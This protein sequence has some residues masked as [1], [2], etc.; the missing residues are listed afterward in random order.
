MQKILLLLLTFIGGTLIAGEGN[1]KSFEVINRSQNEM[2]VK[3]QVNNYNLKAVKKDNDLLGYL[4]DIEGGAKSLDQGTPDLQ[5]LTTSLIIG[6]K[7]P[8]VKVINKKV[9]TF[10]NTEILPSKGKIYRN[11]DPDKIPYQKGQVYNKDEFYPGNIVKFGKDYQFRAFKGLPLQIT[12]MQYNPVSKEFQLFTELILKITFPKGTVKSQKS[13]SREFSPMYDD[14]FLNYQSTRYNPINEKGEMLVF[15]HQDF[16][17]NIE[18]FVEWKNRIGIPTQL[19]RI[20]TVGNGSAQDIKNYISNYYQNNNLTFVLLVGDA[21]YVP[22]HNLS[23]GHSDHA[24]GYLQGNDSYPEVMVGRFSA[25][26]SQHVNTMVNRTIMYETGLQNS[27]DWLNTSLGISSD[28]GPGDNNE[29]DYEHIRNMHTDLQGYTYI[30]LLEMFDGSQGGND[31]SGDPTPSMVSQAINKGTGNILYTGHGSATSWSSS[32]FSNSEI[33]QLTNTEIWPFIWSVACVNGDFVDKTCFAES[34]TR[35]TNNGKPTGAIATQMSSINQSWDPPMHAQDE[36]VDILIESYSNNIKRTFSGISINGCMKMNDAYG[37]DGEEMTD[38]WMIFGDP[39]FMV[40]TDTSQTISVNSIPALFIGDTSLTVNTSV[41]DARVALSINNELLDVQYVKNGSATLT[42]PA[43]ANPDTMDLA[44]VAYNHDIYFDE[45]P[46]M[47][48]NEPYVSFKNSTVDDSQA[49]NDQGAD[50]GENIM[51]DVMLENIGL[52]KAQSVSANLMTSDTNVVITDD[53]A[54]WGDIPSKDSAT[55]NGA[56]GLK[57]K[58]GVQNGYKVNLKLKI[59][60]N[61]GNQWTDKF[62]LPVEAPETNVSSFEIVDDT[63][64]NGD[65]RLNAGEEASIVLDVDNIGSDKLD[66]AWCTLLSSSTYLDVKKPFETIQNLGKSQKRKLIFKVEVDTAMP[67]GTTVRFDLDIS[68]GNY[69]SITS[70]YETIGNIHEGFETRNFTKFSWNHGSN[71]GWE[72]DTTEAYAGDASAVSGLP[73]DEH[74]GISILSIS[75][76]TLKDDT[77][78]FYRKVNSE[79]DYDYLRF[80]IDNQLEDEWAGFLD[81]KRYSYFVP[82]GDHVFKWTYEKD[83][84][85]SSGQDKAWIDDIRFPAI[86]TPTS[87]DKNIRASSIHVYPNPANSKQN[88]ELS[89]SKSADVVINLLDRTGKKIRNIHYGSMTSGHHKISYDLSELSQGLYFLNIKVGGEQ[90]TIK[91]MH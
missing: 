80:F 61:K 44:V 36:M 78:S 68:A 72:I 52:D 33:N 87:V 91:I 7:T 85:V 42:F 6:N 58:K 20:D 63:T 60:D 86:S 57:V 16:V 9:K 4:P 66:Y 67:D 15:T 10:S 11:Q 69:S 84:Y 29:M 39:S 64:G 51:L 27:S 73:Y 41:N 32:N 55:N 2:I 1:Q 46:V 35:A 65:G 13:V 50:Q 17:Q 40:R 28:Q 43:F 70:F 75:M 14:Q 90:H 47:V 49:N 30:D 89:L 45:I 82:A 76:K 54:S 25:E 38:T 83:Q 77:L 26:D 56:Y 23:A 59:E 8:E 88:M 34:W 74:N 37:S 24:Y 53:S 5:H 81:W 71:Y 31:G 18:P 19:I 79:A 62:K 21:N 22:T 3:V 48:A 12:P